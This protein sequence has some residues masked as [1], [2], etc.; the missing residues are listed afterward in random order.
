ML[1]GLALRIGVEIPGL[2][3]LFDRFVFVVVG[4]AEQL[5]DSVT[6]NWFLVERVGLEPGFDVVARE[7]R[8]APM[9]ERGRERI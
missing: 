9:L 3:L 5:Q 1:P 2:D 8:G 4:H 7:P 6:G